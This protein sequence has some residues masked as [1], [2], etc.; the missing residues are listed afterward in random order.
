MYN[1]FTSS[2]SSRNSIVA[3][4]QD[5]LPFVVQDTSPKN[6]FESQFVELSHNHLIVYYVNHHTPLLGCGVSFWAGPY[7]EEENNVFKILLDGL[8]LKQVHIWEVIIHCS[9]NFP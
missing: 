5:I 3:L 9:T 7:T 6:V 8:N 1:I 2:M 4:P